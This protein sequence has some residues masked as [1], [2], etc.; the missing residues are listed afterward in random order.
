M[1]LLALLC[2][3]ALAHAEVEKVKPEKE[4]EIVADDLKLVQDKDK[5]RIN[6]HQAQD[7]QVTD[8][9]RKNDDSQIRKDNIEDVIL[10]ELNDLKFSYI[11]GAN[12]RGKDAKTEVLNTDETNLKESSKLDMPDLEDLKVD[13]NFKNKG[14][15]IKNINNVKSE[16][17]KVS[18]GGGDD[19]MKL[20]IPSIDGLQSSHP[21][22]KYIKNKHGK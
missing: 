19:D 5:P 14:T 3:L 4:Q 7:L 2:A 1:K 20:Y 11:K 15:T 9:I 21:K 22:N 13:T 17:N 18:D 12:G 8:I 16:D 6:A 10:K